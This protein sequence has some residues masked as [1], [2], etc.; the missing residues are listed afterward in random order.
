MKPL[1]DAEILGLGIC[2]PPP[3]PCLD[4]DW[5]I[6]NHGCHRDFLETPQTV[7]LLQREGWTYLEATF[8][9]FSSPSASLKK[10]EWVVDFLHSKKTMWTSFLQCAGQYIVFLSVC[11]CPSFCHRVELI[12][13]EYGSGLKCCSLFLLSLVI[14]SFLTVAP[15]SDDTCALSQQGFQH[16]LLHSHIRPDRMDTAKSHGKMT[17]MCF[18]LTSV[19]LLCS[20][21]VFLEQLKRKMFSATCSHADDSVLHEK[22]T[23][24][25]AAKQDNPTVLAKKSLWPVNTK[26]SPLLNYSV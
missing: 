7:R 11:P 16:R 2:I 20:F 9:K 12:Y 24:G 10:A 6:S 8:L 18:P 25:G 4:E 21:S 15:R 5:G 23:S 17:S 19:M 22:W 3:A 26:L 1:Q 13:V 14:T